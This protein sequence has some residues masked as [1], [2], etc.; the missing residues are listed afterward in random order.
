M[1]LSTNAK[2]SLV[3]QRT[4]LKVQASSVIHH[5]TTARQQGNKTTQSLPENGETQ[6]QQPR[7]SAALETTE[8]LVLTDTHAFS[9]LE[10]PHAVCN[11][12]P[13]HF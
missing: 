11:S 12:I 7:G 9:I 1:K 6:A 4:F 10:L 3:C 13:S 8:V 5:L 2:L